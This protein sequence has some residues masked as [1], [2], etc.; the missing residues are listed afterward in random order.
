MSDARLQ[1]IETMLAHHE[2]QIQDLNDV[3]QLQWK[4]ID[5]LKAQLRRA[6]AQ[7]DDMAAGAQDGKPLSATDIAQR[8][9]P[10]HY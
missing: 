5:L 2:Q 9:K 10:P 4:E 6:S 7:I 8:D 3:I 1:D